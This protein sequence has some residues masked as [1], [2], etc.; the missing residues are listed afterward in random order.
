MNCV[1]RS[2]EAFQPHNSLAYDLDVLGRYGPHRSPEQIEH[3]AV[4]PPCAPL[5]PLGADEV[6]CASLGDV[7]TQAR[8]GRNECSASAGVIEVDVR[9]EQVPELSDRDT[10]SARRASSVERVVA[11]PGSTSAKPSSRSSR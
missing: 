3:V 7:H 11:G 8:I 4:E 2:R 1:A 10:Q 5:E 6:R 9:D